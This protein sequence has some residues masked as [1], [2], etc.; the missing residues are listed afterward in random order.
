MVAAVSNVEPLLWS[1]SESAKAL[2]ISAKTL[3]QMTK[4]GQIPA[5]R[6]GRA[7]RYSPKDL[8]A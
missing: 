8:M 4:D 5:V 3:W 7:V 6:I 2:A 1:V